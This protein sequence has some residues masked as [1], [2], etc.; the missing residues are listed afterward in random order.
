VTQQ[1]ER[2]IEAFEVTPQGDFVAL[3]GQHRV[4]VAANINAGSSV[5][6]ELLGGQRL[7]SNPMGLVF[8]SPATRRTVLLA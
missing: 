6:L 1:W 7:R 4:I 2:S 8:F 5:D 3:R